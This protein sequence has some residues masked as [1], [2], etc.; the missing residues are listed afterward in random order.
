MVFNVSRYH[1]FSFNVSNFI[2]FWVLPRIWTDNLKANT[3][4]VLACCSLSKYVGGRH[5][6]YF[7]SFANFV[8][9]LFVL[10][11][12]QT[13]I[14]NEPHLL[15]TQHQAQIYKHCSFLKKQKIYFTIIWYKFVRFLLFLQI[16]LILFINLNSTPSTT[17]DFLSINRSFGPN[18]CFWN[19]RSNI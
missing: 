9:V 10:R 16:I 15:E 12:S 18:K 8:V 3:Y 5:C 7:F 13:A 4:K 19:T 14:T 6:I 1:S 2:Q 17:N 11:M